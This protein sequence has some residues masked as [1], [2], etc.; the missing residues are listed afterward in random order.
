MLT[1]STQAKIAIGML[2]PHDRQAV[3]RSLKLLELEPEHL[4]TDPR[5]KKLKQSIEGEQLFM[6]RL[7]TSSGLRI[8]FRETAE[9]YEVLDLTSYAQLRNLSTALAQS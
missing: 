4:P 3:Q 9:G 8:V 5:V 1:V 6:L 7:P 2:S